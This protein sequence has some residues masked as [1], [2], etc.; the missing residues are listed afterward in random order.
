M[1]ITGAS[2]NIGRRTAISYAQAGASQIA[3][4]R[5]DILVNN[6]GAIE[7]V[8]FVADTDPADW[9]HTFEVN[10]KGTYLVTRALM[11]LLL[12]S[13]DGSRALSST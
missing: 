11:S 4:G 7:S 1:L 6:A 10:V 5:L 8:G 9:W 12:S 3:V 2:R 13:P